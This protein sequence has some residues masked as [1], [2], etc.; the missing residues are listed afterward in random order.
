MMSVRRSWNAMPCPTWPPSAR[1]SLTLMSSL[2]S[3]MYLQGSKRTLVVEAEVRQMDK[4]S[5]LKDVIIRVLIELETAD[6][7]ALAAYMLLLPRWE[8]ACQPSHGT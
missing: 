2:A 6:K 3:S 5:M 4:E 7:S 1:S 8:G